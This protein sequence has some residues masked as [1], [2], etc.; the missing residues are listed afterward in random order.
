MKTIKICPVPLFKIDAK[1]EKPRM[2]YLL[3]FGENLRI[4]C[5]VWFIEGVKEKILVDAGGTAE[6]ALA[7]GRSREQVAKLQL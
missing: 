1:F 2:T 3:N 6:M 4:H 7:K 5:Y